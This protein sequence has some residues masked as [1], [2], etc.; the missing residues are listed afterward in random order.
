MSVSIE[1]IKELRAA[2]GG[3]MMACKK[4]L[5]ESGGEMEAAVDILRKKGEAKAADRAG[6]STGQGAIYIKIDGKRA[7]LVELQCETDFVARG[8]DFFKLTEVL[9]DKL[10]NGELA[11]TEREVVEVKE[12]VLKFGENI[13]VG[14]LAIIEGDNLGEYIHSNKKIGV[15]V[16]LSGGTQELARDIAMHIA[17]TNPTVISPDEVP[18]ELVAREKAIWEDQLKAEG[19]PVEIMEK[20]MLGKEKKFRE[21]NALLKQ[22]FVKDPDKTI[23]QIL[24]GVTVNSFMRFMV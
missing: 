2:T 9:A 10:L 12:S 6:N 17:A 7:A 3:S 11:V 24:D 14:N 19:K 4:A 15:L 1:Q 20:I 13:K 21:E 5:E 23:E 16:S 8:E 22:Q 18:M